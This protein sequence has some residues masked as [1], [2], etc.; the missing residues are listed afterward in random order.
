MNIGAS[1]IDGADG[2]QQFFIGC[3]FQHISGRSVLQDMKQIFFIIMHGQNQYFG[4]GIIFFDFTCGD[5]SAFSG[6]HA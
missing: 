3:A 1:L 4:I 5:Q 2:E 6:R